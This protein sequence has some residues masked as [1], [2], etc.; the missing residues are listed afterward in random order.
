[1]PDPVIVNQFQSA[2]TAV[3][4]R[5][6]PVGRHRLAWFCGL[7]AFGLALQA[8]VGCANPNPA[9]PP[10]VA[11]FFGFDE[12]LELDDDEPQFSP[13]PPPACASALHRAPAHA[14]PPLAAPALTPLTP[15]PP[16]A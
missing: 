5:T 13:V 4:G 8:L 14:L 7:M 12:A 15:P 11:D 3:A 2:F 6:G 16:F 10:V 9:C 1:M